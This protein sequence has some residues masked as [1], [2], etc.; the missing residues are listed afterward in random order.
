MK[1][2]LRWLINSLILIS[3][4]YL[5]SGIEVSSIYIA[6]ITALFLGLVNALIRPILLLIT[7]PINILTLGLF[8]LVINALLFWFVATFVQGFEVVG[9]S[10]A[11]I[12]AFLLAIGSWFTNRFI[13]SAK[14]S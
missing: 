11:F 6:L 12:G 2:L 1:L 5:V 10:S 3:I 13:A 14:N 9:F 7:L 8:T 4:A